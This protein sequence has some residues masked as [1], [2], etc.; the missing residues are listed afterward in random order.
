MIK[1]VSQ[2]LEEYGIYAKL[3]KDNYL[4]NCPFHNDTNPSLG[5][6]EDNGAFNC[7]SCGAHGNLVDFVSRYEGISEEDARKKI[8]GEGLDLIFSPL[9]YG[10]NDDGDDY[11]R[12]KYWIIIQLVELMLFE[13]FSFFNYSKNGKWLWMFLTSSIE[14]ID[15]IKNRQLKFYLKSE[16]T[17]YNPKLVWRRFYFN[18]ICEY[19]S[20]YYEILKE[21][22]YPLIYSKFLSFCYQHDLSLEL[23]MALNIY[24]DS[25]CKDLIVKHKTFWKY[26]I[27][28]VNIRSLFKTVKESPNFSQKE[29]LDCLKLI[30]EK[31]LKI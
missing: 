11:I 7:W 25:R 26:G 17:I 9:S 19:L 28:L 12:K 1:T 27:F 16:D 18:Y 6:R 22:S 24:A 14:E 8:Y 5:I 31:C 21:P 3:I 23:E 4:I 13:D 10:S 2:I 20:N 15:F 29:K 30:R